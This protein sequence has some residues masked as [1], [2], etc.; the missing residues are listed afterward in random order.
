[1]LIKLSQGKFVDPTDVVAIESHAPVLEGSSASVVVWTKTA[2]AIGIAK[3]DHTA[4]RYAAEE[5]A[6]QVI[7]AL[8]CHHLQ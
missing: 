6:E 2:G 5:I 8:E 1:M 3:A 7:K 4:A